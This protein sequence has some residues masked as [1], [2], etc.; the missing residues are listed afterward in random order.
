MKAICLF[1]S[2][3]SL[4][5]TRVC[6]GENLDSIL[7]YLFCY[8]LFPFMLNRNAPTLVYYIQWGEAFCLLSRSMLSWL[9][10]PMS[11]AGSSGYVW[12]C[13]RSSN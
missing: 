2:S 7:S 1:V 10:G 13:M 3:L 4:F 12:L 5:W 8:A 9:I 6:V 11:A